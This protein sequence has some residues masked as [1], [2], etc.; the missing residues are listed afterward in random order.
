[1]IAPNL[2]TISVVTATLNRAN[3]LGEAMR[4]VLD[5]DYPHVQYV[6]VDGGSTDGSVDLIR[7]HADRLTW[8]CSEKDNGHFDALNKGFARTDGEVMAW[9][10]SDDKYTPWAFQVVG[11]IFAT[12]PQVEWLTTLF[13][14]LWDGRG[15]AMHCKH[16]DG[17][18]REGFRRGEYFPRPGALTSGWIQQESTFWRRS[19]WDKAGGRVD[20][21]I[22]VAGDF[23]LW[24]RFF[25]HA[26]LYGV[27]TPLGG[28]R[29]HG[30]QFTQTQAERINQIC[31]D[32]LRRHGGAPHGR[33][34][35]TLMK[36]K[37]GRYVP[38]SVQRLIGVRHAKKVITHS[39]AAGGWV[40]KTVE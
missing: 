29:V 25:E 12:F 39:G 30:E 2:P 6:V 7:R 38:G 4:S 31:L 3:Y 17:Y 10:N 19:L 1:M 14:I 21:S 34:A 13:P 8:W 36:S 18:S 37:F 28:F 15:R 33:L 16:V 23:E 27:T 5:Q 35:T 22:R 11:E 40:I 32:T 26:D 20:A 24:A 9:L